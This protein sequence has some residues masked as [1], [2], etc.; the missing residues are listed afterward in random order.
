MMLGLSPD[1]QG[2]GSGVLIVEEEGAP[3]AAGAGKAGSS[4]DVLEPA[5]AEIPEQTVLSAA[6]GDEGVGF[7]VGVVVAES[8]RDAPLAAGREDLGHEI[9][10]RRDLARRR[11]RRR[12]SRVPGRLYPGIPAVLERGFRERDVRSF[13]AEPLEL[14]EVLLSFF[15]PSLLREKGRVAEEGADVE[16]LGARVAQVENALECR[17][18]FLAPA[19]RRKDRAD[20]VRRARV[21]GIARSDLLERLEGEGIA[22][23]ALVEDAE[24]EVHFDQPR[25]HL[26]RGGEGRERPVL[27]LVLEV[28][29]GQVEVVPRRDRVERERLLELGGGERVLAPFVVRLSQVSVALEIL[30]GLGQRQEQQDS[31]E[32]PPTVARSISTSLPRLLTSTPTAL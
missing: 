28:R 21:L 11:R 23:C 5:A 26:T 19:H 10:L 3:A 29:H 2:Q 24:T 31:H 16:V 17:L 25:L 27:L 18:G 7:S 15:P 30:H 9:G 14:R 1:V 22:G 4:S 13:F 20:V 32:A 12:R 6:D 8:E